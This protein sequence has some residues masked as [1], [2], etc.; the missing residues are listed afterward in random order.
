MTYGI[1]KDNDIVFNSL[2]P[3]QRKRKNYHTGRSY[4]IPD[5]GHPAIADQLQ[6]MI[7]LRTRSEVSAEA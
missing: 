3:Q 6:Q 2:I 7:H 1:M 5:R 4:R